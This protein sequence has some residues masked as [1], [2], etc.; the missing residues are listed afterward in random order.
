MTILGSWV[1]V[2]CGGDPL[3]LGFALLK[4]STERISCQVLRAA[5]GAPHS[6]RPGL[7]SG[8]FLFLFFSFLLLSFFCKKLYCF[9][10]TQCVGEGCRWWKEWPVASGR[11]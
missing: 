3:G 7:Y 5:D 2:M 4:A 9:H 8:N 11:D 10:S 1:G 6:Q